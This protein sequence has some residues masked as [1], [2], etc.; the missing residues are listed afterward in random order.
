VL[1]LPDG[2]LV[3]A[4]PAGAS[5]PGIPDPQ[6]AVVL[7]GR[8]PEPHPWEIRWVRWPDFWVPRSTTEALDALAEAHERARDQRIE[9]ACRGGVGRTGTALAV[10]AMR[11]GLAPDAAVAWVRSVH[12]PRAVETP[13]Q[14]RWLRRIEV[15]SPGHRD[16]SVAPA[17]RPGAAEPPAGT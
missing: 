2:R 6:F 11:C 4:G 9:I 8:P 7:L 15:P 14:R 1:T 5:R 10:L 13:W 12:H 16:G 17:V 3:R